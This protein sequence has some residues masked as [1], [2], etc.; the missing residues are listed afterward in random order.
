MLIDWFTVFAQ[1]LNFLVLVWLM[2]RFLYRP[3]LA[4]IAAREAGIAQ[5]LAAAQAR[6][7]AAQRAQTEFEQS[8]DELRQKRAALLHK[9]AED[10]NAERARLEEQARQAAAL[11]SAKREQA[12]LRDAEGLRQAIGERVRSEVFA[13]VQK[14][15][16]ELADVTLEERMLRVLLRRLQELDTPGRA[17]LAAL[18]SDGS[19][20]VVRSA[21]ALSSDARAALQGSLRELLGREP[22]L[23]FE[24]VPDLLSGI[25]LSANGRRISWSIS[26]Y[27]SSLERD[28]SALLGA[29]R[30]ATVP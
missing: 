14:T 9:A 26:D 27:L 17:S 28:L 6:E 4:A 2:K 24:V 19:Q 22:Q 13:I 11:R 16:T 15:L 5:Q 21:F 30:G 23:R 3:V 18:S 7:A 25:E 10:A 29:T 20:V 1:G 8:N 12:Q